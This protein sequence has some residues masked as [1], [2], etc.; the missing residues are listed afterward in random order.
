MKAG[1][2]QTNKNRHHSN[3]DDYRR[4]SPIAAFDGSYGVRVGK[5]M[6]FVTFYI[7]GLGRAAR[8]SR[9]RSRASQ[10][11]RVFGRCDARPGGLPARFIQ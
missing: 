5:G 6:R 3:H 9:R 7:V 10:A 4:L 1:E 11:R 8:L 2:T